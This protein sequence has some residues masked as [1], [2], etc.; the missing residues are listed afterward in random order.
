MVV[1]A[2]PIINDPFSEPNRHWHFEEGKPPEM[3]DGRRISGYLPPGDQAQGQLL[4]DL[5]PID[6]VN[7]MRNR[8]RE[9]RDEHYPGATTISKELFERWFDPEREAGTRPFFAQRE[10]IETIAFLTEAPIDRRFGISVPQ[11]EAYERWAVKMATG[12]GKTLVMAMTIAWSVLNRVAAPR[13][14]RFAD[15]V[16]VVAP[17]LTVKDRLQGLDPHRESND[18][19]SF[20]LIPP[21]FA[22]L[23]G[24]ARVL[25]LNWHTLAEAK[26]PKKSV[27]RLGKETDAAFCRRVLGG[28]LGT[29]KRLLVLNDEAHHAYRHKPGV[30]ISKEE[31]EDVEKATVWIDGLAKIHGDRTITK[32]IDFSATPMYVPGSG[33]PPWTPF[34]WVVSDFALVDAIESG[35]VKIPRIPTDDNAGAAIPKYRHLWEHVKASLPRSKDEPDVGHSLLDYLTQVDGPLKQLAGEWRD[36]FER[37]ADAGRTVPPAMV[38]I[39]SDTK[40]AEIL[41]RHIADRGGA[42]PE[43][44]NLPNAPSRTVRIDSRLLAQAETRESS[45]TSADAAER[46]RR[47]VATVGKEGEPGEAVRCL[48]SVAMLSEGWDARNVTQI[49]GLRAFSSQ[50]LCE[51][52]VGRGLRRSSYDDLSVPEYVDVYGVPFQLLPFAKA[53]KGTMVTPPRTTS[54]IAVRDRAPDRAIEFPRLVSVIPEIGSKLVVDLDKFVPVSVSPQHDPTRTRMSSE[55]GIGADDQDR[56]RLYEGYRRQRVT[57]DL[58]TRLVRGQPDLEPLFPQALRIVAEILDDYVVY[59]KGVHEGEIDTELYK[60]QIVNRLRDCLRPVEHGD[61]ALLPVY[62]E[63]QPIGSTATVRFLTAKPV[64]PTTKSHVN[65]VVCDSELERAVARRLEAIDDVVAYVKN[66]HLF[67]EIPYRFGGRTLRYL[68]DFIVV[69]RDDTRLLLEVKGRRLLKDEAK[70]SA[71]H[72]W[73][74]A[75]NGDGRWGRWVHTVAYHE[76]EVA[77]EVTKA[78]ASVVAATSF[79]TASTSV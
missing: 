70:E 71:A 7:D 18:Y 2:S 30:K 43:L 54:V 44:R 53:T 68:P 73:V 39:C 15:A 74:E 12:T 17:N 1:E 38:V 69:L 3:R 63:Y 59:A 45:E 66:D 32:C 62:D 14:V 60:S 20:G 36:T 37:W 13:D 29:R 55:I 40:M 64:E 4:G 28:R 21:H 5:V 22:P 77:I 27:M 23:L 34:D 78:L 61:G 48:I 41:E 6:L 65:Y 52:V 58:A 49:L 75:V 10:A 35:L 25:V 31:I 51:Q 33:H 56:S 9:W 50:L 42:D 47:V 8:V 46:I 79:T 16:L 57:F 11:V 24:Q 26:D 72:R 76:D 67:C 19:E